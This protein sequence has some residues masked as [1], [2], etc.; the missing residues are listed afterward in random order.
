MNAVNGKGDGNKTHRKG[1]TCFSCGQEGHFSQDK[2]CPARG[3][4][5]RK[6]GGTGH[7]RAKCPQLYQRDGGHSGSRGTNSTGGQGRGG[8]S[9][10]G[11]GRGERG[12]RREANLVTRDFATPVNPQSPDYAFSVGQLNGRELQRSPLVTLVIGGVDVP[13]VLIDSGATC[14]V[15]GQQTWEFLKLKGIKCESRKSARELFAY[16][17]TEPLPT[18]GTFTADVTWAGMENGSKADFVVVKGDGRTLL[19][20]ETAEVLSLLRIGPL[21]ANSVGGG[22][23]DGDIREKYKHLFSGVGLLKGY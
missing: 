6:C 1:K 21:Q 19:G 12:G 16:G 2:K 15:M 7:F 5:C 11:R 4:T 13:D 22:Q 3:Q 10:P 17:G 20:R 9:G 14:N 18:L 23:L 8:R